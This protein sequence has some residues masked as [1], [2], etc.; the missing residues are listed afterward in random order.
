M[1]LADVMVRVLREA[2]GPRPVTYIVEQIA[3]RDLYRQWDGTHP[4]RN[5][6]HAKVT[7]RPDLFYRPVRRYVGLVESSLRPVP[8][9]VRSVPA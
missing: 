3:R 9:V 5:H 6:V 8:Y 4:L 2:D 7:K 1:S